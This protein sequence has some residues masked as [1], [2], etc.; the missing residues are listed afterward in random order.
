MLAM[1]HL[2]GHPPL[3]LCLS[4]QVDLCCCDYV[5]SSPGALPWQLTQMEAREP[6]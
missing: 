4:L 1:A 2:S 6:F 5:F 3:A